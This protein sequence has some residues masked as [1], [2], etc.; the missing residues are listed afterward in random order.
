MHKSLVIFLFDK[1]CFRSE[2]FSPWDMLNCKR[3]LQTIQ[4]VASVAVTGRLK[5]LF[6]I[7]YFIDFA[8]IASEYFTSTLV[9]GTTA[10]TFYK[11]EKVSQLT[12]KECII[13]SAPM[14]CELDLIPSKLLIECRDSILPAHTDLLNSSFDM[15]N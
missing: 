13:N 6:C 7:L 8:N 14:S 11:F 5:L 9:T 3:L 12:V 1:Q 2:A 4:D 10:A 15:I